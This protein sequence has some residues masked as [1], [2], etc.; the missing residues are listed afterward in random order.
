MYKVLVVDDKPIVIHGLCKQI[1][2]D[3]LNMELAG[4]AT[5]GQD[6]I[7][8]MSHQ[9]IHLL[10]TDVCMPQ[11]DGLALITKAK[12]INPAIR[13][14]IIS[15][16]DEF[17]YVKKALQLGVENYLLKPINHRELNE[18]LTKTLENL[19]RDQIATPLLSSDILAFRTN[20]LDRWVNGTIQD[21]ELYERAE[22]LHINLSAPEYLVCVLG[23]THPSDVDLR[24]KYTSALMDICRTIVWPFCGGE[25]FLDGS[26]RVVV[27]LHGESLIRI[28]KELDI[29]LHKV[30]EQAANE[31]MKVFSSVGPIVNNS[32]RVS[33]SYAS[34]V[35]YQNYHFVN[36][37]AFSVFCE[38]FPDP[39]H[40]IPRESHTML[41][42]FNK[43]L[44]EENLRHAL[45][46]AQQYM[47]RYTD[48]TFSG[49]KTSI[50][51]FVLF[52]IQTVIEAGRTSDAL[53]EILLTQLSGFASLESCNSLKNWLSATIHD[54][55]QMIRER[56]GTLHLLVRLSLE[57]VN[58]KYNEDLSLKTLA[59]GF[60]VSP[61]YLGQLFKAETGVLF[62]DYLTQVRLQA[63]RTLL[64]ETDLKI[65]EI[66]RQIGISN[67]SY[68]NRVFKKSYGI[69]PI[70]FRRRQHEVRS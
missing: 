41:L 56:R 2:W 45:L 59:A 31:S 11:M 64:L 30:C 36:P 1:D 62:N 28:R 55:L 43:A 26:F 51:P 29:L 21:F 19:E 35:F 12:L 9:P 42:Q 25:Y 20:I 60:N 17:E 27:I 34:A 53:P 48:S 66:I 70:E 38:D 14:I 22:L 24:F 4:T 61:A 32:L 23:V 16:H 57:Q 40:G 47:E 6:A 63:A 3:S 8:L 5:N 54:A 44:K 67:Q 58:K 13:C 52:L 7:S 15:A 39:H 10:V 37:S 50:L 33:T 65:G 18:T 49:M 69:S 46:L 68:F